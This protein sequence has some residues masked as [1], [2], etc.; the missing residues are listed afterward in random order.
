MPT[1]APEP[2]ATDDFD[3]DISIVESAP[4]VPDLMRSTDNECGSTCQSAC[5]SCKS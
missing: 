2:T 5:T 3:L 1:T 4:A